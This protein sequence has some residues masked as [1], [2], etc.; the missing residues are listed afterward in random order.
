MKYYIDYETNALEIYDPKFE[1]RL[2][3]YLNPN[4]K[5]F[6]IEKEPGIFMGEMIGW[7]NYEYFVS[8]SYG[9][10]IHKFYNQKIPW[11]LYNENKRWSLGSALEHIGKLNHK[12]LR[13]QWEK[14]GYKWHDVPMQYLKPY[15]KLDVMAQEWLDEW[16]QGKYSQKQI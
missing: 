7:G 9:I 5:V 8:K 16:I 4:G 3:G 11:S 1:I 12:F 13:T 15:N 2:T 6:Q 10:P 14:L